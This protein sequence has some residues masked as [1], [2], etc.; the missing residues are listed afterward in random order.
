M[1]K[2]FEF[3]RSLPIA[4]PELNKPW[5]QDEDFIPSARRMSTERYDKIVRF[6]EKYPQIC[7]EF[8]L[9]IKEEIIKMGIDVGNFKIVW[10]GGRVQGTPFS[11]RSDIDIILCV[12]KNISYFKNRNTF[13][14]KECYQKMCEI[15]KKYD[16]LTD[17]GKPML[18][19]VLFG[20]FHDYREFPEVPY[21]NLGHASSYEILLDRKIN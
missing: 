16:L 5:I 11:P 4:R 3:V 7:E 2:L 17:E 13:F 20:W 18:D 6:S 14:I 10:V 15:F 8:F 12:E 21:D 1:N 9:F 19:H